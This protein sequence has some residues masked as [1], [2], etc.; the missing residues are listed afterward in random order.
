MKK[1]NL[2][3][4]GTPK[5]VIRGVVAWENCLEVPDGIIESMDEDV[6]NWKAQ[7][8]LESTKT[9]E[10][11]KSLYN[12]NGPIRFDPEAQFTKKTHYQFLKQVQANALNKA[13]QY[14]ELY[15]DVE[16]EVNW[17]EKYQYITYSPPKHMTYHSDNHSVRNPK[18]NQYYIAPYM[19]RITILTYLN[20][21]FMGGSLKFR[22]FPEADPYKP[23][24][25]SVVIMPSS[26]V[27]SH[28]TTPLLNGRKSAFLVS[29][30]SNF[31]MDSYNNGNPIDQIKMREFS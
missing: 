22:Y 27:Y 21:N 7:Q 10:A 31:D 3:V 11:A 29:L 14:F 2:W 8:T 4:S 25:G 20:D 16:K 6:D 1:N 13:A 24:A 5:E 18:T 23:P 9:D 28:A 17:L 26:F 12:D 30:S 19:R 15:P